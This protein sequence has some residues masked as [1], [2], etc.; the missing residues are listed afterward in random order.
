VEESRRAKLA[1]HCVPEVDHALP[2]KT[3]SGETSNQWTWHGVMPG[4]WTEMSG[5]NGLPDL[6]VTGRTNVRPLN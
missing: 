5:K 1:L 3:P 2:G 4:V 6:L